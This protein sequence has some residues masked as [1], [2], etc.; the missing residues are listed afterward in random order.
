MITKELI[1][2]HFELMGKKAKDK[3]TGFKGVVD[4]VCFD[5]YGCIQVSL[6]PPLDKDGKVPD[7]RW[8]DVTRIT[9]TSKTPVIELPNYSNGYIAEGRKGPADK[10]DREV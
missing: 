7:G 10:P 2:Q 3:I 1:D 9:V 5:L 4:S 8:F 6:R